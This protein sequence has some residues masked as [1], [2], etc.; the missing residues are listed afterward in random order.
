LQNTFLFEWHGVTMAVLPHRTTYLHSHPVAT[1]PPLAVH[2]WLWVPA[3]QQ[4]QQRQSQGAM[5]EAAYA[6]LQNK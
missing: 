6:K 5:H 2:M 4:E 3:R 1:L